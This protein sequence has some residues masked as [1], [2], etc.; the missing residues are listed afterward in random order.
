VLTSVGERRD[1]HIRTGGV[2]GSLSWPMTEGTAQHN[3]QSDMYGFCRC[4][5]PTLGER[6]VEQATGPRSNEVGHPPVSG[7]TVFQSE[8][9]EEDL[10]WLERAEDLIDDLRSSA[11]MAPAPLR[12]EMEAGA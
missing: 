2:I 3:H 10:A 1:N 9:S 4:W 5:T 8:L 11:E 6:T 12:G 7:G